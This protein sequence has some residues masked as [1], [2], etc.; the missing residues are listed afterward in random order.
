VPYSRLSQLSGDT[1]QDNPGSQRTSSGNWNS[2]PNR[3]SGPSPRGLRDQI[4]ELPPVVGRRR[5]NEMDEGRYYIDNDG[6]ERIRL[7]RSGS[8][9]PIHGQ[10]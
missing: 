7:V 5:S 9:V 8:A 2:Y 4:S 10:I 6:R 3:G 1:V